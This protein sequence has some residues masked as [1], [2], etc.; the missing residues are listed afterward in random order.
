MA[1]PAPPPAGEEAVVCV[2]CELQPD[3]LC[4]V[5]Y[6][7]LGKTEQCPVYTTPPPTTTEAPPP[8]GSK[9][10]TLMPQKLAYQEIIGEETKVW[11]LN[12]N[13]TLDCGHLIFNFNICRCDGKPEFPG[14]WNFDV[15]LNSDNNRLYAANEP[16]GTVGLS[17]IEPGCAEF[18]GS[19]GLQIPY[20]K[21]MR[22]RDSWLTAVV[23]N[24]EGSQDAVLLYGCITISIS[25]DVIS[26]SVVIRNPLAQ[27]VPLTVTNDAPGAGYVLVI[28][29]WNGKV[30]T[31][32][33]YAGDAAYESFVIAPI[34][35]DHDFKWSI[36]CL[37]QEP[38]FVGYV[39]PTYNVPGLPGSFSGNI[40]LLYFTDKVYENAEPARVDVMA[41]YSGPAIGY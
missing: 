8:L 5:K 10:C 11:Y 22:P 40:C 31:L 33:V 17:V 37:P 2:S 25:G 14:R 15:N 34:V 12:A 38:L 18:N 24:R 28:L 27:E 23:F 13:E 32:T 4:R 39:P 1:F 16:V 21:N 30:L 9:K 19:G 35:P 7:P 3:Q 36:V 29:R 26:A 20:F 41:D 6:L